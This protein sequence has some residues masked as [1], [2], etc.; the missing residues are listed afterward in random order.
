MKYLIFF[1]ILFTS[2]R[3]TTLKL[4]TD[5]FAYRTSENDQWS[6]FSDWIP[7][8]QKI[9]IKDPKFLCKTSLLKIKG[10]KTYKY[11]LFKDSIDST[12][13]ENGNQSIRINAKDSDG[14]NLYVIFIKKEEKVY[15]ITYY[16]NLNTLYEVTN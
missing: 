8:N 12:K 9:K 15:M 7:T 10:K 13:D 4:H 1:L 2:C 11:T 3:T 16:T 14:S 5:K 6:P